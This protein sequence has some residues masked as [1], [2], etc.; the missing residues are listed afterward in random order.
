MFNKALITAASSIGMAYAAIGGN[1]SDSWKV[2]GAE[3]NMR[4]VPETDEVEIAVVMNN[5]SWLGLVLGQVNMKTGGDM[6]IFFADGMKSS[7][8]DYHSIGYRPPV[9]DA[10]ENVTLIKNG[11]SVGS[12][13]KVTMIAR[14]KRDT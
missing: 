5:N 1:Y 13:G 8:G 14:R 12:D 4:I 3:F 11:V 7:V 9:K 6:V 10:T 2:K